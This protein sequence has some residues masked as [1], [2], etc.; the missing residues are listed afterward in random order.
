[1]TINGVIPRL[2]E[3]GAFVRFSHDG[4]TTAEEVEKKVHE[5]LESKIVRPWFN[6][7]H[8]VTA[9]LV[10]GRPWVEDLYRECFRRAWMVPSI[11]GNLQRSR[12]NQLAI[13]DFRSRQREWLSIEMVFGR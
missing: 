3:G 11:L 1:M 13:A 5:S 10:H 9:Q 12:L 7:F 6:P 4:T 2:K 8:S